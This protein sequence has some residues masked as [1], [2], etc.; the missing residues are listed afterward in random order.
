MLKQ[1][2]STTDENEKIKYCF[3]SE[4]P[5]SYERKHEAWRQISECRATISFTKGH[6]MV[7]PPG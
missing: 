4:D 2:L 7:S 5:H 6:Y 1:Y 3:Q